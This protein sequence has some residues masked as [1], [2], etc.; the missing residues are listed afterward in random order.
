ML[1]RNTFKH[2]HTDTPGGSP[3]LMRH[4]SCLCLFCLSCLCLL[5]CLYCRSARCR[6]ATAVEPSERY[7]NLRHNEKQIRQ[8][9]PAY[10]NTDTPND[11]CFN[12]ICSL[13][14]SFSLTC[15]CADV[16]QCVGK[17]AVGF[18]YHLQSGESRL[19]R[20][21]FTCANTINPKICH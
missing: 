19:N 17:T 9:C 7:Q 8:M 14:R 3:Y 11:W 4:L 20:L 1:L 6:C 18:R 10:M 21:T 5:P 15:V 16:H 2:R 13:C 12:R